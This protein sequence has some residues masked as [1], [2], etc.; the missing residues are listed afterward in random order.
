[1]N[2]W[3]K[4]RKR[5]PDEWREQYLE[6]RSPAEMRRDLVEA[7]ERIGELE[8]HPLQ[9]WVIRGLCL[10]VTLQ[11][12]VVKWLATELVECIQAGHGVIALLK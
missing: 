8:P 5:I 10:A 11:F 3:G 12:G 1:M 6:H 9:K 7:F 2:T 4:R